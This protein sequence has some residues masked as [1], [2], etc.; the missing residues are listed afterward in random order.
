MIKSMGNPQLLFQNLMSQNPQFKQFVDANKNKSVD[1]I[2]QENGID[3][4]QI[5]NMFKR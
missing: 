5:R 4:T 3:L 2:A 1:Q